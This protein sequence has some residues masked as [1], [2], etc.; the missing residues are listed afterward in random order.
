MQVGGDIIFTKTPE[1]YYS[2]QPISEMISEMKREYGVDVKI[3]GGLK[4][5]ELS[6]LGIERIKETGL[7]SLGMIKNKEI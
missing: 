7:L 1:E 3:G 2:Y 6:S 5:V 4:E